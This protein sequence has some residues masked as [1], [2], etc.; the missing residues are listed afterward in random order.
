MCFDCGCVFDCGSF[1]ALATA[2]PALGGPCTAFSAYSL[3][4]TAQEDDLD[5]LAQH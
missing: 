3:V 5:I 2:N 4:F 1:C